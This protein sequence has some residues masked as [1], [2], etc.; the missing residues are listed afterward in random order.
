M[1]IATDVVLY[2]LN[3]YV[4][5]GIAYDKIR[6]DTKERKIAKEII[7]GVLWARSPWLNSQAQ[8]PV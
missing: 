2:R 3:S 4:I 8:I 7:L 6:K 1:M 5:F